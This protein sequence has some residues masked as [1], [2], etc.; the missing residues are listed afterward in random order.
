M[1]TK[2]KLYKILMNKARLSV[3]G[4]SYQRA[5]I[6]LG[7]PV[8]L[9]KEFIITFFV[10]TDVNTGFRQILI[11]CETKSGIKISCRDSLNPFIQDPLSANRYQIC[12]RALEI[13]DGLI[14]G[15]VLVDFIHCP[16]TTAISQ[17]N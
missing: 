16:E 14:T 4:L 12:P 3:T 1:K 17:L 5:W 7:R 11:E 2:M 9:D 15:P 8:V 6:E 13:Y 10:N